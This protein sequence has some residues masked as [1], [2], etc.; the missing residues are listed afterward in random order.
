MIAKIVQGRGFR[1]VVNYVLD[2]KDARLLYAE[3][4][5]L[6][7]KESVIHS[8]VTQSRLNPKIA[9]PVAHI[10][11]NFSAQDKAGLTDEFMV[12]MAQEY[13]KKMGYENTQYIIV[14]HHDTDHPHVHLV[15]GRID[16]N[17]KRITDQK[18]KL[19]STKACM[20]LTRAY[21]L[22]IA[23]GKENVK[24]HRLKEP[25]KTKYEIYHALQLAVPKCRNWQELKAELLKSGITTEFCGNGSTGKIQGVRFGKNG[26]WFNGSKV[27]R[28]C[29]YSK[30]DYR[31]Q[32]N[33]RLEQT[34]VLHPVQHHRPDHHIDATSLAGTAAS[35][36][37]GLLG[38]TVQPSSAYEKDYAEALEQ[39][40]K[41]RK[42]KK[43]YRL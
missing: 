21:G 27:D 16:N 9:K 6:K 8:F 36:L 2:K 25:E 42:K 13:L 19:R 37:G 30:I 4:V 17:G 35:V 43:G 20:E 28:S 14:R 23:S 24:Q 5:R 26:Y 1:G 15:I 40:R 32:Q 3:G 29:S 18:E 12:G 33:D 39:E 7:D 31:L 34:A 22:Y 10:S 11:L 38:A 41:K